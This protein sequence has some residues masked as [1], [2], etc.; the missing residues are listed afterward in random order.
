MSQKGNKKGV[1]K[2]NSFKK[3]GGDLLFHRSPRSRAQSHACMSYAEMKGR[4]R[5][6]QVQYHRRCRAS[7]WFRKETW[8][9]SLS[10]KLHVRSSSSR[11]TAVSTSSAAF[12]TEREEANKKRSL[13]SET[14][15]K[16][17]AATYF[18]TNKC[19]IIGDVRLN[20]SVRNGKR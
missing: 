20:F 14:P 12:G 5:S 9:A 15:L 11:A 16:R 3:I 1:P 18:S 2:W 17:L 10:S 4:R 6:Q 19:S 8:P 13:I 7:A